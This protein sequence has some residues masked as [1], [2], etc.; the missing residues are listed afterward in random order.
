M[1]IKAGNIIVSGKEIKSDTSAAVAVEIK[2]VQMEEG[3]VVHNGKPKK[4]NKNMSA[5]MIDMLT[6]EE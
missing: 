5:Y 2:S 6:S 1:A 3:T 4:F